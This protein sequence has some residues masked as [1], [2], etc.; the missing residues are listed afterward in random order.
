MV[1]GGFDRLLGASMTRGLV[2]VGLA[3]FVY[4]LLTRLR[5]LVMVAATR[6]GL[7]EAAAVRIRS[8]RLAVETA[9]VVSIL[10]LWATNTLESGHLNW[11]LGGTMHLE[12]SGAWL[13]V[14]VAGLTMG[15]T[16]LLNIT[17]K[18]TFARALDLRELF[19]RSAARPPLALR[20]ALMNPS[21]VFVARRSPLVWAWTEARAAAFGVISTLAIEAIG[22]EFPVAR[23]ELSE[24]VDEADEELQL[25]ERLICGGRAIT[26]SNLPTRLTTSTGAAPVE[27][28]QLILPPLDVPLGA[29]AIG[30]CSSLINAALKA[31]RK[32]WRA[33][34]LARFDERGSTKATL[35]REHGPM[36]QAYLSR[37]LDGIL[38]EVRGSLYDSLK[39]QL[40]WRRRRQLVK[41]YRRGG[42][43][44]AAAWMIEKVASYPDL[45]RDGV[46]TELARQTALLNSIA[47]EV[48]E[49]GGSEMRTSG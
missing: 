17:W 29:R 25:D 7:E 12:L 33:A 5:T 2:W 27:P 41:A 45:F 16:V 40:P 8:S 23:G 36:A 1:G 34:T 49:P 35:E 21:V 42:F 31:R 6:H 20:L 3:L 37:S 32:A 46:Y 47:A 10:S 19:P 14:G 48:L 24:I 13:V 18:M 22:H 39:R 43:E 4:F 28:D 38:Y 44:E 9:V 11:E 30:Y 26:W 15:T